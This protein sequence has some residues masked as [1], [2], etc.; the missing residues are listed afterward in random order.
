ML[1]P[2]RGNLGLQAAPCYINDKICFGSV[3]NVSLK[4]EMQIKQD[5]K[6]RNCRPLLKL[7]EMWATQTSQ[8]VDGLVTKGS[9]LDQLISKKLQPNQYPVDGTAKC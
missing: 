6:I 8:I 9:I 3:I 5:I 7:K 2:Y 4:T 1:P